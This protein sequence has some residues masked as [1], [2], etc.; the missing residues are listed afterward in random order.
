MTKYKLK[1]GNKVPTAIKGVSFVGVV[2]ENDII[3]VNE[4]DRDR[5]L[6]KNVGFSEVKATPKKK[7]EEPEK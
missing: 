5:L 7:D 1:Y 6:N 3:E 4:T 2:K